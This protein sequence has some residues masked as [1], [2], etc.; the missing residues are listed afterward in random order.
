MEACAGDAA[1]G[2]TRRKLNRQEPTAKM[3]LVAMGRKGKGRG[4]GGVNHV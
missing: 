3:A 2:K 4:E 1:E